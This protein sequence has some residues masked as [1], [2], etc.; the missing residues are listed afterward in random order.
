MYRASVHAMGWASSILVARCVYW[1]FEMNVVTDPSTSPSKGASHK[2]PKPHSFHL[3]SCGVS[4]P[5]AS[6]AAVGFSFGLW[7]EVRLTC[8]GEKEL[9]K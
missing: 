7:C 2:Y 5:H 8:Y 3:K 9:A 6:V 4:S 1:I